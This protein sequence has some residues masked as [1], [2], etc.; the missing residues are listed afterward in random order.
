MKRIVEDENRFLA[1]GKLSYREGNQL[2]SDLDAVDTKIKTLQTE[3]DRYRAMRRGGHRHH[4]NDA[5]RIDTQQSV[6]R[7]RIN[8]GIKAGLLTRVEADRLYRDEQRIADLEVQLRSSGGRLGY[9]EQRQLLRELDDLSRKITKE[10]NDH[11]V[12]F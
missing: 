3:Y 8:A 9:Q 4:N 1:D 2:I 11:Q 10:L 12:Q 6:L 7:Q 5:G